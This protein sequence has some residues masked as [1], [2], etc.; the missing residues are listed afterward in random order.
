[1]KIIITK[2]LLKQINFSS[3]FHSMGLLSL[4]MK[5]Q[6]DLINEIFRN[7]NFCYC[8]MKK[9]YIDPKFFSK[10]QGCPAFKDQFSVCSGRVL[11][12]H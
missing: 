6:H 9:I 4:S 7:S 3:Q 10:H 5:K 12:S 11:I 1:M 2:K 8:L